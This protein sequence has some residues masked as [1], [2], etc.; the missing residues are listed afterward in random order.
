MAPS[1]NVVLAACALLACMGPAWGG[2]VK[3]FQLKS[4]ASL[5]STF[6]IPLDAKRLDLLEMGLQIVG[7]HNAKLG[8]FPH[9][10]SMQ[11][12]MP[13]P[14]W[15]N[16]QPQHI[17]GGTLI[18]VDWVLTAA[19]CVYGVPNSASKVEVVLGIDNL[20]TKAAGSQRIVVSR[21]LVHAKYDHYANSG[22]GP[23]DIALL[24]LARPA[25]LTDNIKTAKLP[26]SATPEESGT[27][28]LS[29]WGSTSK[30]GMHPVYP[31]QLQTADFPIVPYATCVA[32]VSQAA[33]D[34]TA[35]LLKETNL[36]VGDLNKAGVS[37]CSG[38]SGG[39]LIQ[40][41]TDGTVTVIGI[42]SWGPTNCGAFPFPS[43]FTRVSS[44][45]DW[46]KAVAAK[47]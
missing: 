27:A 47:Y 22:V 15:I 10:A 6:P 37:S 17:C 32:F 28:T 43:V 29:G 9:Q 38:D 39:P 12:T 26:T 2:L 5:V 36:C 33:D 16:A 41:A 1:S 3:E 23:Y 42:V 46:I 19:H 20:A 24:K 4:P 45:L 30:D 18:T 14:F 35:A 11:V 8:E 34:E 21:M 40:K 7:G 25:T 31:N 13:S 44:Y